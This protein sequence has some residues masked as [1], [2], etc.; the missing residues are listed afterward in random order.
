MRITVNRL[1]EFEKSN[2]LKLLAGAEGRNNVIYSTNMMDNP[3]SSEWIMPGDLVIT[4][5]FIFKDNQ[6]FQRQIVKELSESNCSALALKPRKYFGTTPQSLI[7]AADEFHLPLLEIPLTY[8]LSLLAHDINQELLKEQDSMIQKTLYIQEKLTEITLAGGGI[9]EITKEIAS[10]VRNPIIVVSTDWQLL[11]LSEHNQNAYPLIDTIQMS[12]KHSLFPE[13]FKKN[14][15]EDA[16]NFKKSIKRKIVVDDKEIICRIVPIKAVEEI[17]GYIVVWE[18][19]SK[20]S[21][22]DYIVI[23]KA[24]MNMALELMKQQEVNEVKNKI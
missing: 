18:T 3:E 21:K 11:A 16:R 22:L 10:T 19:V 5:G 9:K 24:A 15:P 7:E 4:T 17:L 1:L 14:I 12:E 20:M 6:E 13:S 8:S 2:N 23:E